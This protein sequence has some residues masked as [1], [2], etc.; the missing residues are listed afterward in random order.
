[1][2][3]TQQKVTLW[4]IGPLLICMYGQSLRGHAVITQAV[5]SDPGLLSWAEKEEWFPLWSN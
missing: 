4:S 3:V 2:D 5:L 1:M